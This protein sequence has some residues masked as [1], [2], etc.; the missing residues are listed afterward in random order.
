[1]SLKQK[2]SCEVGSLE[3]LNPKL[4]NRV[5]ERKLDGAG[6]ARLVQL[7][8]SQ[9]PRDHEKWT[10]QLLADKLVTLVV[11]ATISGETVRRTLKKRA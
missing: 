8:C 11:V 5:Y 9:A 3:A 2:R 4:R 6:E 7:A 10:L 1:M